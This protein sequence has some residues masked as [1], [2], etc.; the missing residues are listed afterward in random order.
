MRS[1]PIPATALHFFV[2]RHIRC[3]QTR[4]LGSFGSFVTVSAVPSVGR[5]LAGF[6]FFVATDPSAAGST[7]FLRFGDIGMPARAARHRGVRRHG[8]RLQLRHDGPL[9]VSGSKATLLGIGSGTA[10]EIG[11]P[12][13]YE[14]AD[15]NGMAATIGGGGSGSGTGGYGEPSSW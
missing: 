14:T 4:Q 10:S 2:P 11:M 15:A 9:S 6:G 3:L 7:A 13:W 12:S 8:R 5:T 1:A